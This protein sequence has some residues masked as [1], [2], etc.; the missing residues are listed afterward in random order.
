M[1]FV[2][3]TYRNLIVKHWEDRFVGA[4]HSFAKYLNAFGVRKIAKNSLC[5]YFYNFSA[6]MMKRK[7]VTDCYQLKTR[8]T[9]VAAQC[10]PGYYHEV[11]RQAGKQGCRLIS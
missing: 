2:L 11:D 6:K 10:T 3:G 9:T 7:L 4:S 1:G 5:Y 8:I